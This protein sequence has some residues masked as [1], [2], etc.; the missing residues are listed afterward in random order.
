MIQNA[1]RLY[2]WHAKFTVRHL[3]LSGHR[4]RRLFSHRCQTRCEIRP[5][6]QTVPP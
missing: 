2:L 6:S 3:P 1:P 4:P 5:Q